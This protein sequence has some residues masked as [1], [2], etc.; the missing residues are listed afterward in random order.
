MPGA[1]VELAEFV[2]KQI[3]RVIAST[4]KSQ[5]EIAHEAGFTT[6]NSLS[7]IRTGT[8]K[9]PLDRVPALAAALNVDPAFLFR[10]AAAQQWRSSNIEE[11]ISQ[12]FG[13]VLTKDE[14]KLI[15]IW[16]RL[17]KERSFTPDRDLEIAIRDWMKAHS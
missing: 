6:P 13:H 12:V 16:R 7:M 9:L 17:S 14:V 10:L 11:V 5:R 15:D 4:G 3:D 2:G 8:L 1:R